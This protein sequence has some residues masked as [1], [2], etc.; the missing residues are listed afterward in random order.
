MNP[1]AITL[2][3]GLAANSGLPALRSPQKDHAT[4]LVRTIHGPHTDHPVVLARTLHASKQITPS[5]FLGLSQPRM[6]THR[7][8]Q[9]GEGY[10]AGTSR[11]LSRRALRLRNRADA[12]Q[13]PFAL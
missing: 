8:G 3:G 5:R 1:Q 11:C 10:F 2:P 4:A 7:T 9:F 12:L 6:L 13:G